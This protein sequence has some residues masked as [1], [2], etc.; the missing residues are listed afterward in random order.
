ME[1]NKW[2]VGEVSKLTGLTIRTLHYYDK[3]GLISPSYRT[4]TGHRLYTEVDIIKLQQIMS[5]KELDFSLE[6]IK[7]FLEN[8][9]YN[10][11]EIIKMQIIKITQ[12]IELKTQLKDQLQEIFEIFHSGNKPTLEMFINSI[13]LIKNHDVY[14]TQEQINKL[15]LNFHKINKEGNNI[16]NWN[17]L[18]SLLKIEMDKGTPTDHP[19]VIEL[20]KK[21]QEG[22][23]Y[24]T[25]G[26]T[27]ILRSAEQYYKDNP[28]SAFGSGMSG[29]LYLYISDVLTKIEKK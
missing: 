25:G 23:N 27:G 6:N 21:W 8:D 4:E 1:R 24:F 29:E 12:E 13:K 9:E 22:I 14:F 17:Q 5:L 15:K 16:V 26:D 7:D 3:I 28:N 10:L 11:S 2:K 18:I 20:A 19:N